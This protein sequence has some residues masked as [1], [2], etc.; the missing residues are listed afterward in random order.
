MCSCV[1]RPTLTYSAEE[2]AK[3]AKKNIF[4][5]VTP[6]AKRI[7]DLT[8]DA[9]KA[10]SYLGFLQRAKTVRAV[11]EAVFGGGR[12][13]LY[14]PS[15]N[16]S[17]IFGMAGVRCPAIARPATKTRPVRDHPWPLFDTTQPH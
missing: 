17:F 4:S 11:V 14:A 13:K 5:G 3:A 1:A 12:V 7:T 16:A 15:E 9:T 8:A 10:K 6:P 2:T